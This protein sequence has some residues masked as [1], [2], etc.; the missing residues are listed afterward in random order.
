MPEILLTDVTKFYLPHIVITVQ[1]SCRLMFYWATWQ[2]STQPVTTA[3]MC[4]RFSLFVGCLTSQQQV[5]VCQGW[6]FSG[7]YT[8]CHTEVEA[9]DPTFYLTQSQY[10]DI[11]PTSPSTDAIM[12]GAWQGSHWSANVQAAGMIRPGKILSPVGFEPQIF[13]SQGGRLNH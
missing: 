3:Q 9:A 12:P 13:R 4:C 5:S 8:C 6:I 1:L 10:T 2:N 11:G 7:N